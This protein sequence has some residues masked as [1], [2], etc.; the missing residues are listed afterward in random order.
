MPSLQAFLINL[1]FDRVRVEDK[2][3][4]FPL[5]LCIYQGKEPRFNELLDKI[6]L[7]V[8]TKAS[9]RFSDL[10]IIPY[11]LLTREVARR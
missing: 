11:L 9:I 6:R 1:V 3:Y 2:S 4:S 8:S 10:F 5:H 7:A